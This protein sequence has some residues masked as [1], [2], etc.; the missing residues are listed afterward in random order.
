MEADDNPARIQ[1]QSTR[2]GLL[3]EIVQLKQSYGENDEHYHQIG[4]GYD[5]H[6][7]N[8][9]NEERKAVIRSNREFTFSHPEVVKRRDRIFNNIKRQAEDFSSS[10][11]SCRGEETSQD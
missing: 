2:D 4:H 1:K 5:M 9:R 11:S 3:R 10:S 8:Q 6:W 7:I